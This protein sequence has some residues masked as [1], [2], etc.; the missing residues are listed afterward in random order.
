[1]RLLISR[2]D[3]CTP[4]GTIIVSNKLKEQLAELDHTVLVAL[5]AD[6]AV[7]DTGGTDVAIE[8]IFAQ[9][10]E[11]GQCFQ[12][13]LECLT[14]EARYSR[15]SFDTDNRMFRDLRALLLGVQYSRAGPRQKVKMLLKLCEAQPFFVEHTY[16]NDFEIEYF[17]RDELS[18][19][20]SEQGLLCDEATK[21][22]LASELFRLANENEHGLMNWLDT[23]GNRHRYCGT[24]S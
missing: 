2:C 17:Y 10:S 22:W 5:L 20:L 6:L 11:I 13:R 9:P 21:I 3:L 4:V 12:H 7:S 16:D 14:S 1:M 18:V 19:I 8:L 23:S 15:L 24:G